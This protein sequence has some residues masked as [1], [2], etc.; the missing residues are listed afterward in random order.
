[1]FAISDFLT[2]N[3]GFTDYDPKV[4]ITFYDFDAKAIS[5]RVELS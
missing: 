3:G 2:K 4:P 1:M 5:N